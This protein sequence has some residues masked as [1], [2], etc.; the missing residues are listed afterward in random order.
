ME[1][2]KQKVQ[3]LEIEELENA[4]S[5]ASGN[6]CKCPGCKAIFSNMVSLNAHMRS[7]P[8]IQQGNKRT[9]FA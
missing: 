3:E 6:S 4:S 5:G 7:C 9:F 8:Q 1:D 2:R